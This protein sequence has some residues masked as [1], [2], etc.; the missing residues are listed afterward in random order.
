MLARL[1]LTPQARA[2]LMARVVWTKERWGQVPSA[3]IGCTL[4][5]VLTIADQR[6]RAGSF[7]GMQWVELESGHSPFFSMP[8]RLTETLADLAR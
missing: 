7:P 6:E 2:P 5:R 8:E 3:Y 4:D 1:C